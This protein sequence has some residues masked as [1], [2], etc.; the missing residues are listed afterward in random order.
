MQGPLHVTELGQSAAE[1]SGGVPTRTDSTRSSAR[2]TGESAKAEW[3][4][5]LEAQFV[6]ATT[7]VARRG[8]DAQGYS[9]DKVSTGLN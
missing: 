6:A 1:T 8:G 9:K 3:S 2:W 4:R 7:T 5:L